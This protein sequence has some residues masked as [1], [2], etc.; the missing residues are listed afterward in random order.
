MSPSHSRYRETATPDY[1]HRHH[2]GNVGDVW[3]HCALLEVLRRVATA[4]VPVHYIETHAGEGRYSLGPTGEWTEGIGQLWSD[5]DVAAGDD[6][7]A[8]YVTRCRTLATGAERPQSYPGSP[9]LARAVLGTGARS[10]LWELDADAAARL[11]R[12]C[13]DGTAHVTCGD[14][15][16]ALGDAVVAAETGPGAVVTLIDPP[17]SRKSDWT[18]IPDVL[19]AAVRASTRTTFLLW[20]PVKSLTRPNAML[21]RLEAAGVGGTIAELITTPLEHTR[22]RLNGSGVLLVRPPDGVVEVLAAAAPIVGRRCA[23]VP[24]TWSL[25]L[26]AWR[27]RDP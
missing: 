13:S 24:D 12:Q 21:A 11:E 16:A 23:T 7:V 19:A 17:W 27:G 8:R 10:S 14:G 26:R 25:R 4:T 18:A 6:A 2:A 20:Y 9:V 22:N 15:L 5:P 3:K 1:G